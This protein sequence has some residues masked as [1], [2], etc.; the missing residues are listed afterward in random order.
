M[1]LEL[2]GRAALVTGGGKNIGRQVCLTLAARGCQVAVL[3]RADLAGAQAVVDELAALGGRGLAIVADVGDAAAVR[4]A[5]ERI[6]TE[7]G[8]IDILA[9]CAGLRSHGP[10]LELSEAEWQRVLAVNLSGPLNTCRAVLPSMIERR[11]GS[12][13]N[14]SGS[15]VFF[16]SS[17]HLAAAKAGLHGLTRGLAREFGPYGIRANIVVPST[18]DSV[19]VVPQPPERVAAEIARTPLG[20]I[21]R[22][23][24]AAET[25]AF[26]ASDRASFIT[27]QTIHVNGGQL[28]P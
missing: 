26:L 20:R 16:G 19:R 7:F 15:V 6:V 23:E 4:V 27:G 22:L 12:I 13:V 24:E 18:L 2:E 11:S 8:R 25:I 14:L 21:G 3:V 9:N 1:T 28:M 10:L 17:P 5:V